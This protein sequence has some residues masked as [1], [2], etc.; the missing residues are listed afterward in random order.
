[1]DSKSEMSPGD[2]KT[3]LNTAN[4]DED[5]YALV[6]DFLFYYGVIGLRTE[7]GDQ[8]IFNVNYDPKVLQIRAE[9]K[10]DDARY[11]MNPAFA[12]ALGIS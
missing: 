11:V 2:L 1:M 7:N 3:V 9:L 8:Y 4:V 6:I 10:G 5:D 12:L